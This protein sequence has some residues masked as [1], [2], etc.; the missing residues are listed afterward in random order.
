MLCRKI[1][2]KIYYRNMS[3][4]LVE[5]NSR[6]WIYIYINV[7]IVCLNKFLVLIVKFFVNLLGFCISF[8]EKKN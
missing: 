7:L 1:L 8:C 6:D 4:Y 5:I 2:L 3:D